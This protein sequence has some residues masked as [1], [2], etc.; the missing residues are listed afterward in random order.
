MAHIPLMGSH[1]LVLHPP[2]G[3]DATED[4]PD[5]SAGSAVEVM[6]GVVRVHMVCLYDVMGG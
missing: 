2:S 6:D 1:F 3:G 5:E 4:E